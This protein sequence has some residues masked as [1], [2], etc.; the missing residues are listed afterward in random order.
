LFLATAQASWKQ[1]ACKKM[2]APSSLFLS[3]LFLLAA[4]MG[5][6]SRKFRILATF[7][8]PV[9]PIVQTHGLELTDSLQQRV[10]EKVNKVLSSPM[11]RRVLN[12]RVLLKFDSS[13]II[14]CDGSLQSQTCEILCS[15]KDGEMIKAT[16]SSDDMHRSIDLAVF[17]LAQSLK[18]YS[19]RIHDYRKEKIANVR[20]HNLGIA[21]CHASYD[22]NLSQVNAL[23]AAGA[24]A[25]YE[26]EAGPGK[27]YFPLHVAALN[28]HIDVIHALIAAGAN[29]NQT[30]LQSISLVRQA[31]VLNSPRMLSAL[32]SAGADVNNF[33]EFSA[34]NIA[35]RS[36]YTEALRL[37]LD[38]GAIIREI[39]LLAATY[40]GHVDCITA[41][42]ERG[43]DPFS[44]RS[45]LGV[46]VECGHPE[47]VAAIRAH[48]AQLEENQ[49]KGKGEND[50]AA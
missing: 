2:R 40:L 6:R 18:M 47:A 20:R 29:V 39:D 34:V 17:S 32:I 10:R 44:I 45:A 9:L 7:K 25:S 11:S 1:Q 16:Q 50:D 37:L 46:A 5:L 12:A 23:L 8:T 3:L 24:D 4:V 28:E 14:R 36:G 38:A 49:G 22:N 26:M 30:C 19:C 48:L 35:A 41:L 33:P 31:T 43:Y 21:L 27:C 42:L 15:M 13:Q